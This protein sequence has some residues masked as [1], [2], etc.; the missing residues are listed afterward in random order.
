MA[1]KLSHF[2]LS[3]RA[4]NAGPASAQSMCVGAE[5]ASDVWRAGGKRGG[6]HVGGGVRPM[7]EAGEALS[8]GTRGT[9]HGHAREAGWMV[10]SVDSLV[11][12]TSG[13]R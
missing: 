12:L 4:C 7:W 8:A 5:R 1:D 9:Q 10:R 6:A 3:T 13:S 2:I 11:S